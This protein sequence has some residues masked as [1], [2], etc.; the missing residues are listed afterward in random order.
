MPGENIELIRKI[1]GNLDNIDY[2]EIIYA[3]DGS[4]EGIITLTD[5]G[6]ESLVRAVYAPLILQFRLRA[7]LPA[8]R[9]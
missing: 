3:H 1:A 5:R 7:E 4:E 9:M 8:G 2:G 6:I